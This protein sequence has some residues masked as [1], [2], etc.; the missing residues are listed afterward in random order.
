M[1][2]TL[3]IVFLESKHGESKEFYKLLSTSKITNPSLMKQ[4]FIKMEF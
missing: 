3:K 2:L 1:S 4:K